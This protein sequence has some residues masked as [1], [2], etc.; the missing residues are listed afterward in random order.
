MS[1]SIEHYLFT[2]GKNQAYSNFR[3][4]RFK[5]ANIFRLIDELHRY[6]EKGNDYTK[7][8]KNIIDWNDL[9]KYD[10]YKI[11]ENYI[12]DRKC[13]C[14]FT[15]KLLDRISFYINKLLE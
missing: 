12:A 14:Y 4:K 8:L 7:M 11:D 9:V 13:T 5:E 3:T 1:E 10:G 2:I 6:S 15:K